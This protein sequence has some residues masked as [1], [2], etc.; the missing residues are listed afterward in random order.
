MGCVVV[1]GF[2]DE[3]ESKKKEDCNEDILNNYLK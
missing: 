2:D 1:S 3:R